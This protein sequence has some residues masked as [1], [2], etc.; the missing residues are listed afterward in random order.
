MKKFLLVI[1]IGFLSGCG[2]SGSD[3]DVLRE[4]SQSTVERILE[5]AKQLQSEYKV[6]RRKR[7]EKES[8]FDKTLLP[9]NMTF[10][11]R[12]VDLKYKSHVSSK[13]LVRSLVP[14]PVRFDL[15][16]DD[17]KSVSLQRGRNLNT[18]KDHLDSISIQNNWHYYMAN[19]VLVV[20]DWQFSAIELAS[21]VGAVT[22]VIKSGNLGAIGATDN[23]LNV[24]FDPYEELNSMVERILGVG[25]QQLSEEEEEDGGFVP[26]VGDARYFISR[27]A[28]LLYVSAPPNKIRE[29]ESVLARY[30][31]SVSRRVVIEMTV[32]DVSLNDSNSRFLDLNLLREAATVAAL[33]T[34]N[35][36]IVPDLFSGEFSSPGGFAPP[37]TEDS[38]SLGLNYNDGSLTANIV[39]SWLDTQG[40]VIK[41]NQRRFDALNNHVVTF[42]DT[43]DIEYVR[44]RSI[45]REESQAGTSIV[46]PSVTIGERVVGRIF[47][48]IP[49]IMDGRV[50]IQ[51]SIL[52]RSIVS[53]QPYGDAVLSGTLFEVANSDR[54]I[55][56]S[57]GDGETRLITYFSSDSQTGRNVDNKLLPLVGDKNSLTENRVETV[58]VIKATIVEGVPYARF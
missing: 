26:I 50:N 19:G 32:Y 3:L 31:E 16:D 33:N 5:N 30:N 34:G 23:V 17:S 56:L 8:E 41:S 22:A 14:V 49:T 43:R 44:E 25:Q 47:N 28:N 45:E 24:N 27:S 40:T 38:L 20:T 51:M 9:K 15:V 39:L 35:S 7:V 2:L 46:S 6:E 29:L 18:V 48:L 57:L 55:P 12:A 53:M 21:I 58:I 37:Y 13:A 10:L 4:D 42:V 54:M 11:G 52:D 1:M 36:A